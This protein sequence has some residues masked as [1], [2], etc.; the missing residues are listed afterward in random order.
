MSVELLKV[1]SL[2][3]KPGEKCFGINEFP[4]EGQPYRLPTWLIN[5]SADG[6]TLV[7]PAGVHG[8]EYASIAAALN[9]GQSLEAK[10]LRGKVIVVP[11]MISHRCPASAPAFCAAS[12]PIGKSTMSQP[13]STSARCSTST[14]QTP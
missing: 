13:S 11:T 1:G 3:A 12:W 7:V 4:V 5:G 10:D 8:A 14:P 6:P 2:A 9:L